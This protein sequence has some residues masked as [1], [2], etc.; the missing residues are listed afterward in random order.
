M[1]IFQD[2]RGSWQPPSPKLNEEH[3]AVGEEAT[4]AGIETTPR[5]AVPAQV[6]QTHCDGRLR[7]PPHC[8]QNGSPGQPDEICVLCLHPTQ[9]AAEFVGSHFENL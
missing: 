6:P 9:K 3:S 1:E 8:G 4:G 5:P 7:E 2:S